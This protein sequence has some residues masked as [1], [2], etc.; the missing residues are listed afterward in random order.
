M[1]AYASVGFLVEEA[2]TRILCLIT[3]LVVNGKEAIVA[4]SIGLRAK[5][6]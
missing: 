6:R 1:F 3:I 5:F 2:K 4:M